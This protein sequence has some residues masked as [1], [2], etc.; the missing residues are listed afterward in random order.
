MIKIYK[1]YPIDGFSQG[2]D[3]GCSLCSNA[4]SC[5]SHSSARKHFEQVKQKLQ[6]EIQWGRNQGPF[7]EPPYPDLVCSPLGVVPNSTP[8][9]FRFIHDLAF[10]L[11][12]SVNS[13]IPDE[14]AKAQYDTIFP[15]IELVKRFGK[16][17]VLWRRQ[18]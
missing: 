1:K 3:L 9:K 2:F 14:A 10:P 13:P 15:A 11:Q 16:K 5:D 4:R 6:H 18:T 8:G 17:T 12:Y 7:Q